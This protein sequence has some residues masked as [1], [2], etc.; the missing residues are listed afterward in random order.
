MT[1]RGRINQ[2]NAIAWD[3]SGTLL[4]SCSD[5]HTCKIWSLEA[6]GNGL[7]H[8][9]TAHTREIYTI[10]WAPT[11]PGSVNPGSARWCV[12]ARPRCAIVVVV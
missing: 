10:K 11:G 3:P 5:D 6:P 12:W 7:V 8:D 4:A 1:G 9:F 2:V